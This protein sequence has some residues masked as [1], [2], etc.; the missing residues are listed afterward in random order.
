MKRTWTAGMIILLMVLTSACVDQGNILIRFESN[1]GTEV[2]SITFDG[3]TIIT[4]PDDPSREGYVFVDWY[5]DSDLT[6][7]F[8][9]SVFLI[10]PITANQTLYA[11]WE[12]A[13]VQVTYLVIFEPNNGDDPI[14]VSANDNQ[15]VTAI[16]IGHTGHTLLGWYLSDDGGETFTTPWD[17]DADVVTSNVVLYAFWQIESYQLVYLEQDGITEVQRTTYDY[18]VELSSHMTVLPAVIEGF[19]FDGWE[20][21]PET[22]PAHDVYLQARYTSESLDDLFS[23]VAVG[24]AGVTYTIPT[25]IDD[26]GSAQVS[27]GFMMATTETTYE[28]WYK[29][30]VWAEANGYVFGRLGKEGS[31]GIE[32]ATP[33]AKKHEPVTSIS[34]YDAIIWTNALSEMAGL[35]PVYRTT[36]DIIRAID[37]AKTADAILQTAHNGYRLPTSNEWEMAA[38]WLNEG[39]DASVAIEGRHW[40]AGSDASG[41]V[42]S[43]SDVA[44]LSLV[45]WFDESPDYPDDLKKTQDVGTKLANALGLYDM[46]GNVW[47][48]CFDWYPFYEG[49]YRIVRGGAF[50]VSLLYMQSGLISNVLP[51]LVHDGYGFRLARTPEEV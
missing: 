39:N 22:M 34:W 50:G 16:E 43:W 23:E 31:T 49:T 45:G 32:G 29:V 8:D 12:E 13:P 1:G 6:Q 5:Q 20:P 41:S 10:E 48:F 4:L 21:L 38:R 27:G 7:P 3:K 15:K 51:I 11:K 25:E 33:T 44:K 46:A 2:P 47:E 17:F 19:S 42:D 30:R 37:Q 26:S 40:T 24:E 14:E 9:P 28:L 36:N 18:G 35:E